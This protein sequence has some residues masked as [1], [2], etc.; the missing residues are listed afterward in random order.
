MFL[1]RH[2]RIWRGGA[3]AWTHAH[4]R[5]LVAQRFDEPALAATSTH[6]R[7]VLAARDAQLETIQADLAG[8]Q[9]RPP[10]AEQVARLAA[11]R[12]ITRLGAVTLAAEVGDWRRFA[13]A[14]QF[15]GF[16][17]LV[18]ANLPAA[19]GPPGAISSGRQHPPARPADRV[20]LV[21]PVPARGRC[22]DRRPPAGPGPQVIARGWGGP[23]APVRPLLPPGRPQDLH[24]RGGGGHRPRARRV[25]VGQ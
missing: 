21:L 1:L 12:G 23:A 11:Y 5:W 16:C 2:G 22:S 25:L 14:S 13:Q 19:S 3:T 6:H 4:E 8:W 20:G 15:M 24:Q 9:D 7:A 17:G 10:F 18:P